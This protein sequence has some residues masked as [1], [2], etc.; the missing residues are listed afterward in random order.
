MY[1]FNRNYSQNI[2]VNVSVKEGLN[3]I[4]ILCE[5]KNENV[6][7]GLYTVE[8]YYDTTSPGD[9]TNVTSD[10]RTI[11]WNPAS[12]ENG[13]AYYNI[14]NTVGLIA[15]TYQ[16]YWGITT[17]DNTYFVAAVDNAGNEGKRTEFN[18]KREELLD[19]EPEKEVKN[20]SESITN[21][22][23][24]FKIRPINENERNIIITIAVIVVLYILWGIYRERKD[25][26]G[27]LRYI[28]KR[29]KMRR[30]EIAYK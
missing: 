10:N 27:L 28:R 23:S 15:M 29:R 18:Q 7:P 14:Y 12:D 25:P 16:T 3:R 21:S 4:F 9:V 24:G 19:D 8:Y 17:K 6:M 13:I 22:E 20:E 26:H 5:D 30:S 11:S 1:I 2:T